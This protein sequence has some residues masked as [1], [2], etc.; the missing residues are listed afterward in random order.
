ML[1][2][3]ITAAQNNRCQKKSHEYFFSLSALFSTTFAVILYHKVNK[4][5]IPNFADI[6]LCLYDYNRSVTKVNKKE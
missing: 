2:I 6:N 3:N 1:D 4:M 5:S